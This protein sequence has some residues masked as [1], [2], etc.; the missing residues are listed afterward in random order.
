[1]KKEHI[2]RK[3][4][5][6]LFFKLYNPQYIHIGKYCLEKIKRKT[7]YTYKSMQKTCICEKWFIDNYDTDNLIGLLTVYNNRYE[8][9]IHR[10]KDDKIVG[11]F[12]LKSKNGVYVME[13][14][15]SDEIYENIDQCEYLKNEELKETTDEK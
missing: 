8:V 12:F 5:H 9:F 6:E 1:M 3:Y 15:D 4:Y 2:M 14:L 7:H 10:K 13:S 11:C